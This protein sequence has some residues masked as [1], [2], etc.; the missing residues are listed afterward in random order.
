M[1]RKGDDPLVEE[2]NAELDRLHD[3]GQWLDIVKPFGFTEDNLPPGRPDH[4]AVVRGRLRR[5]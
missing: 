3:S 4:R 2:F 1:F 5:P